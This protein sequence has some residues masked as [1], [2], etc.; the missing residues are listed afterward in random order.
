MDPLSQIRLSSIMKI[1]SGNS[2]IKIGLI[3]GPFDY[4]HTAFQRSKIR[5]IK[6]SQFAPCKSASSIAC[7][8]CTFIAG[9]LCAE[10]GSF[11]PAIC[12]GCTL[13]LRPVFMEEIQR[14][15]NN[16]VNKDIAF[17]GPT[18]E[19]LS[20][21]IIEVVDIGARIINLSLGL[22]GSSLMTYPSL[23]EAYDYAR[24][25][26]AVILAAIR[27]SRKYWWYLSPRQPMDHTCNSM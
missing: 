10:R 15:N 4:T 26:E 24:R 22:S 21:A 20:D 3:D 16:G 7:R 5:V 11:A 19:E 23:K 6:E 25:H 13:V 27:K 14:T 17:P 8:H 12:P 2:E 18:P 1:S 9:I